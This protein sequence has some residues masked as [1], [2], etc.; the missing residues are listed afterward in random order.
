MITSKLLEKEEYSFLHT[1]PHLGRHIILLGLAGSYAY[2]TNNEH[3]D[4]DIRGIALNSRSDLIGMTS[5]EQYV[6]DHTDTTIYGFNKII[7]LLLSCNPNVLELLGLNPEHYLYLNHIGQSLLDNTH[8]FLSKRAIQS[9]GGYADAQLRRLQNALARDSYPQREKEQHIFNS[10]KNAMY[11]FRRRYESFENGAI[12]LYTDKS[13]NPEF[14]TEIF[15]DVN[16]T[17][18][19]LRDYKNIWN[20]MHNIVRDYDKLGKRN[21]KKDDNHLNKH[22]MHLVRLFMTAIDILEKGEIHTYRKDEQELLLR[23]RNGGFQK[24]DGTFDESFYD[25]VAEYEKKLDYAAAHTELP[26]EP[27]MEQVQAFVMS[28]N[29]RVILNRISQK[30][31]PPPVLYDTK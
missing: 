27:D 1:N 12:R 25:I 8:L 5:F 13:A 18:Y 11:D 2:G 14:D 26:D 28:V 29:E 4:I 7:N 24:E 16:L 6:D 21:R 30:N 20:E 23:I 3:S 17:H 19:P 10:V 15:V 31:G 9:F 22:A